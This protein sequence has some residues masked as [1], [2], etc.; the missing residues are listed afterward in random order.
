MGNLSSV[1]DDGDEGHVRSRAERWALA[2]RCVALLQVGRPRSVAVVSA[3]FAPLFGNHCWL[4]TLICCRCC[5]CCSLTEV[6]LLLVLLFVSQKWD[7]F[8]MLRFVSADRSAPYTR[9]WLLL[10]SGCL[11]PMVGRASSF[12]VSGALPCRR[13]RS[14]QRV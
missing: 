10:C 11:I 1:N 13:C 5:W 2:K 4:L 14:R 3:F 12:Y 8:V 6:R 9:L 7:V